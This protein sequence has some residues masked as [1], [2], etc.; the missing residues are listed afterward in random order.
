[1]SSANRSFPSVCF[2]FSTSPESSDLHLLGLDISSNLSW[3]KYIS[4]I[5]E[6]AFKQVGC[7]YLV[8]RYLPPDAVLYLYKITIHPIMEYCCH[9]WGG[10]PA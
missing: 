3:D 4:G 5:A 6:S 9:I 2:G 7:L 8:Q 10:A 1:M